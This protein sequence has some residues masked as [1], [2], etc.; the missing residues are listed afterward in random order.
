MQGKSIK[1]TVLNQIK[2]KAILEKI[3]TLI[4]TATFI[5]KLL[6]TAIFKSETKLSEQ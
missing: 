5:S 6:N 2:I 4:S 3:I 1:F